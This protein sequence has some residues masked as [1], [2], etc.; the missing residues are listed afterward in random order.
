MKVQPTATLL[1]FRCMEFPIS[2]LLN[3]LAIA[4]QFKSTLPT[5]AKLSV[6]V[7]VSPQN[8]YKLFTSSVQQ[9]LTFLARTKPNQS[10]KNYT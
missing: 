10:N 5:A 6:H 2:P 8:I 9:K 3:F 1:G 7:N 4:S